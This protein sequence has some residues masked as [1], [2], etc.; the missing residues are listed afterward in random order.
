MAKTLQIK[1]M[2]LKPIDL[3]EYD[4]QY[5]GGK[6]LY[7]WANPPD[8]LM[9]ALICEVNHSGL[10]GRPLEENQEAFG[11]LLAT[12]W[13]YRPDGTFS[14]D[15]LKIVTELAQ[16]D[17]TFFLWLFAK[18]LAIIFQYS[19]ADPGKVFKMV[20]DALV[21]RLGYMEEMANDATSPLEGPKTG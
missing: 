1:E 15:I 17:S 14:S 19:R 13:M 5:L 9:K 18:T 21:Q 3:G 11:G 16:V 6:T 2:I 10:A 7:T 8:D 12:L 4:T 20:L